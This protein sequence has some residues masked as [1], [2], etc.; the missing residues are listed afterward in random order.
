VCVS[1]NRMRATDVPDYRNNATLEKPSP[2]KIGYQNLR[3][4]CSFLD[5]EIDKCPA[6][7]I[8]SKHAFAFMR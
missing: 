2:G 8:D 6:K 3:M 4:W 1:R 5:Q 7:K